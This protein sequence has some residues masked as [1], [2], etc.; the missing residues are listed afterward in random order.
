M[1]KALQ[2]Q[3][4][5]KEEGMVS[6]FALSLDIELNA[7][8]ILIPEDVYNSTSSCV[9]IDLGSVAGFSRMVQIDPLYN[10]RL[11][12]DLNLLCNCYTIAF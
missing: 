8:M 9:A 7:P 2:K 4:N 10:Y 12:N 3:A 5:S 1:K 6:S 11:I